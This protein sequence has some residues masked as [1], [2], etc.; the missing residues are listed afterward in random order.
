MFLILE[1]N[2]IT[3]SDAIDFFILNMLAFP[4]TLP[5]W[6][7]FCPFTLDSTRW[8]CLKP[9]MLSMKEKCKCISRC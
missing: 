7:N 8:L 6:G 1:L 4:T 3:A 5:L 9:Q 2:A